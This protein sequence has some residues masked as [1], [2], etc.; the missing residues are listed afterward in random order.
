MTTDNA[1]TIAEELQERANH[2][3]DRA[4]EGVHL[5]RAA[6]TIRGLCAQLDD[7]DVLTARIAEIYAAR[8][9]ERL[10][11]LEA[12]TPLVPDAPAPSVPDPVEDVP[13]IL[14]SAPAPDAHIGASGDE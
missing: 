14:D 3:G 6:S 4:G 12:S 11:A 10:A 7:P 1:R 9:A 8:E 5:G 2:F 13:V